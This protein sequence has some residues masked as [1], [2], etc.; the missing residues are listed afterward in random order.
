MRKYLTLIVAILAVSSINVSAAGLTKSLV[1][2]EVMQS[3]IT[4]SPDALNE[5]PDGWVELYNPN[6]TSVKLTGYAIGKKNKFSK[7]YVIT[8]KTQKNEWFGNVFWNETNEDIYVPAHGYVVIYCDKESRVFGSEIH[9]DFKLPN[10]KVGTVYLYDPSQKMADSLQLPVLAAVNVAYGRETDGSDKLGYM[11]TPTKGKKNAGGLAEMVLGDPKFSSDSRVF[12]ESDGSASPLELTLSLPKSSPT[13]AII[14]YTLNGEE[15]TSSSPVYDAPL[16]ISKTTIVKAAVYADKCITPPAATRTFLYLGRKLSLPIVS[17]ATSDKNLYDSKLGIIT[18]NKSSDEKVDW[19]RPAVMSFFPAGKNE[20][21]FDQLCEMRVGGGYS[22]ANTQKSFMVYA[23]ARFGTK[24]F[25]KYKFWSDTRPDT[26]KNPSISLRNAGNDFNL[27]QMRDGVMHM[28]F[29]MNTDVDWQAFQP[30]IAFLNGQYYGILNIRERSN[31]DNIWANYD[32][33][34]DI[35]MVENP[36]WGKD[37]LKAGEWSQW[38]EFNG[39]LRQGGVAN[40]SQYADRIDVEEFANFL[41]ANVYASNTDFPGNNLVMWRPTEDGGKW[42]FFLK[43]IDRSFGFCYYHGESSN[44]AGGASNAE[45]LKWILRDPYNVFPNNYEGANSEDATRLMRRIMQIPEFKKLFIDRFT[46]Y[47]GDFLS[48]DNVA[49]VFD[50]VK[51]LM[52]LEMTY[53]KALYGGTVSDWEK[54]ITTMKTWA[55]ERNTS[56]Y[57]QFYSYFKLGAPIPA[58]IENDPAETG[59]DKLQINGIPLTTGKFDGKLYTAREYEI[60]AKGNSLESGEEMAWRVLCTD[61]RGSV[62][63]DEVLNSETFKLTPA[64]GTALIRLIPTTGAPSGVQPADATATE[65]MYYNLQG[66]ASSVPFEGMNIVRYIFPD[67]SSLTEKLLNE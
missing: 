41:I 61:S 29:G 56:L 30:A 43:D 6:N 53:H 1:I 26:E 52:Q 10:D 42:R 14:R 5:Y 11:L 46:V 55:K 7:C 63:R 32:K 64:S 60:S 28:L 3:N 27:G 15:P 22:R 19:R 2:N 66:V 57:S 20:A 18:N 12:E 24:D 25:F 49:S 48:A 34:E 39:F 13:D 50:G 23:N 4:D 40:Y 51:D 58:R 16:S 47:L 38:E 33:L 17:L 31:E 9:S 21:A 59:I 45:Y 8:K 35:T 37:G 36:Y 65:I 67:G 62:L 54:E 44:K